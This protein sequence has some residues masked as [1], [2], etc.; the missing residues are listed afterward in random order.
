MLRCS[1]L[2][3]LCQIL[4]M[5]LASLAAMKTNWL[6]VWTYSQVK[7]VHCILRNFGVF[8][9]IPCFWKQNGSCDSIHQFHYHNLFCFLLLV[10]RL[11]VGGNRVKAIRNMI[12]WVIWTMTMACEFSGQK[13]IYDII[14][15][16][17]GLY[18]RVPPS[19]SRFLFVL[20]DTCIHLLIKHCLS[21]AI[22]WYE[23]INA[24]DGMLIWYHFSGK[25]KNIFATCSTFASEAAFKPRICCAA[26]WKEK[27]LLKRLPQSKNTAGLELHHQNTAPTAPTPPEKEVHPTPCKAR[28]AIFTLARRGDL[29][30][31]KRALELNADP[32]IPDTL[33]S[34]GGK[35]K[36][37][38]GDE[39][40]M[41]NEEFDCL[42]DRH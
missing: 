28:Q 10:I 6:G 25:N 40:K 19:F 15:P 8:E 14:D 22:P 24:Y 11:W 30:S 7:N 5:G 20:G 21:M 32:N 4:P 9:P 16:H 26:T 38:W 39:R 17:M 18:M 41:A 34:L 1:W 12:N 35:W 33:G 29:V 23:M 31:V 27:D 13:I 36:T 37:S 2:I 3:W 42:G